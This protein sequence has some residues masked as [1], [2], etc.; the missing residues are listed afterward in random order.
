[1]KKHLPLLLLTASLLSLASCS[2]AEDS[3]STGGLSAP[4]TYNEDSI[5]FHY[6]RSDNDYSS[7]DMWLWESGKEGAGFAFNGIDDWGAIAAYPLSTWTDVINNSL[8]FI[9]RKGGNDWVSK[10]CGGKD[11]FVDFSQFN[12]DEKGI[13]HIYM[14][15]GDGNI[16]SDANGSVKPSITYCTFTKNN[17]IAALAN[18][19]IASYT[20]K[21]NGTVITKDDNA[22]R[23]KRIDVYLPE[24]KTVDYSANYE[25]TLTFVNGESLSATV[26][27]TNLFG[28]DD[29]GNLYNY[30]GTDLG[31]TYSETSSSFA[32]WSPLSSEITLRIYD[33]GTPSS[34]AGGSD[35][36]KDYAMEKSDKGVYRA[37]VDGDLAGKYYTYIVTNGTY[38]KT[39]IVDPYAKGCGVNGLRGMIVDFSKTNPE[40]WENVSPLTIDRKGMVVY[41]THVADVTSSSTWTGTEANRKKFAG[42]Y[43]GGTTYSKDGVSVKTG[44][45]HIKELGVNAVQIVP[46]FDQANDELNMSFNWGYNPLNYNCL[47]GGYSSD[48]KDGYARIKEFK[49]LVKKYNEAG[50]N[51]IMDVVYNHV[52]GASKSNFDVLMPG[53]YFRYTGNMALSNG[54]G[55]GNETASEHYMM[56][57]FI[58]ESS[59]FW[60]KEYKL[61]GFRFDLMGLH[62]LT[63]MNEV[64]A[65]AKE[66]NPNIVIYGE[67]WQGGTSTLSDGDSAKQVNGNKYEGYGQF[68]DQM[69]D[70]LIRGGLSGDSDLGWVTDTENALE[71][72]YQNKLLKGIQGIT[73]A[74]AAEIAD[75]DKTVSYVTCHDNYTLADRVVATGKVEKTDTD[76]LSK[77]NML[78]NSVA[79]TSQGT[80]FML[81]GEEMLRS[82][83]GNK[84]S[85]NASYKVNELDYSLKIEHADLFKSYQKLIDL[86]KN[87][88]GLHLDKDGIKDLK[89]SMNSAKNLIS[90]DIKDTKNNK[91]YHII[92]KNGLGGQNETVDLTDYS[93]Y[94]STIDK[95]NKVL[96]AKTEIKPFETLIVS[97]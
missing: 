17:Q 62:D 84:N 53:Y 65:K 61:G 19:Q 38:S 54:S 82:K 4:P 12:K 18:I 91:T 5:S 66:I 90:Y 93:L 74:P 7:W 23:M 64:T 8:G 87:L 69:R 31:V 55:C 75:P 68:N 85:Y 15:S 86:K 27:K 43:E 57:K 9:I 41:E 67:P 44:F 97:K 60:A 20:L 58:V 96:S 78:A 49:T 95:D 33:S 50:M 63:T 2:P 14:I 34:I 81:A 35:D 83:D 29:F 11:L 42:M 47:E 36:H 89:V 16:Y 1:M 52:A 56:R 51:I 6:Q 79:F 39:E 24:G 28:K 37:K 10:D 70:A 94:W 26:D 92:H 3:S 76:T 88:D 71:T 80:S 30:D 13:Y 25:L 46:I 21:E 73:S 22:G 40:G 32:V 59:S 45:D 72:G 77:M 48:P